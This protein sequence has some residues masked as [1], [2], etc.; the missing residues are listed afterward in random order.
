VGEEYTSAVFIEGQM[1]CKCYGS[2]SSQ[3]EKE[4]QKC[5]H[6][7]HVI[8]WVLNKGQHLKK[9]RRKEEK[10][11]RRKDN[12]RSLVPDKNEEFHV[13]KAQFSELIDLSDTGSS[14]KDFFG[15]CCQVV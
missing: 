3:H 11:E 5:K 13:Y 9:K 6:K 1:A 4:E 15:R 10:K 8:S 14:P 12:G 7:E 2:F